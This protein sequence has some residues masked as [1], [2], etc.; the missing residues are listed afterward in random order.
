M[1]IANSFI[2]SISKN[3]LA[4]CDKITQIRVPENVDYIYYGAFSFCKN[5]EHV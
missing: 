4:G 5:L 2:E 1:T 3:T